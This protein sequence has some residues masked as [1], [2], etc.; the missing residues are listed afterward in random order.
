MPLLSP[1]EA[2]DADFFELGGNSLRLLKSRNRVQPELGVRT[3][4]NRMFEAPTVR[5]IAAILAEAP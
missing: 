3:A 2:A 4:P 1:V 5:G